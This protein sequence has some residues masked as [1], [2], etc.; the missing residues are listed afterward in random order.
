VK[1]HDVRCVEFPS[2]ARS[3]V[4]V[5]EGSH[6]EGASGRSLSC[7]D[8]NSNVCV[9]RSEGSDAKFRALER[10]VSFVRRGRSSTGT[11]RVFWRYRQTDDV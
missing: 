11:F 5:D 8:E 7:T 3:T 9:E 4:H 10:G 1:H 6:A 2:C